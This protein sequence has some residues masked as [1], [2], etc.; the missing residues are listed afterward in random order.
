MTLKILVQL[1]IVTPVSHLG[2]T[3]VFLFI[4]TIVK[5]KRKSKTLYLRGLIILIDKI[6]QTLTKYITQSVVR[7]FLRMQ[8]GKLVVNVSI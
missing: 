6:Y 7:I 4:L 2:D 3:G 1:N 5:G 8:L